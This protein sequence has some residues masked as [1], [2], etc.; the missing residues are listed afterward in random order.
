MS[1]EPERQA[2][3][4]CDPVKNT[5]CKKRTCIH[6]P[7]AK[8]RRCSQTSHREFALTGEA[9]LDPECVCELPATQ[10]IHGKEMET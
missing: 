10:S 6:N 2:L 3:Y 4:P 5:E 9:S 7:A 8:H 1:M